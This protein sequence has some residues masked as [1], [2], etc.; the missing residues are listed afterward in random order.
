MNS[1]EVLRIVDAI[2][3]DKNIDKEIV[4]EGIEQAILSAARK[5]YGEERDILVTVDRESGEVSAKLDGED[6]PQEELDMLGRIA[7]QTAKQVMIQK[8]R[9]AE[10]DSLFDEFTA[11]RTELVTGTITRIDHGVAIVNLG[12]VEALLPRSEQIPGEAHRVNERVRAIVLEVRKAGS[13]VKVILSRTHPE[14]VRRLFEVEIPEVAE[15]VIEVRSLAREAGY[16]S[17]VAV[18]CYDNNIDAVGACV[19][20]RGSRIR[21]IV[22]ELAGERID[23]VRWNDSL[24][25]LI[26]N[27]LQPAE[28][29]DVILC[30]MLGRVIVLVKEDQLS[31]AIGKKGQNVRLA[32]KLVGWDIEVMTRE[33]LDEQLERS[34]GAFSTVPHITEELAEMLVSQGFFS[35]DDLSVIEPDQLQE[36]GGLTAEQC[37]EIVAHADVE[38]LREEEEAERKKA[39]ARAARIAAEAAA[40]EAAKQQ[41]PEESESTAE[42]GDATSEAQATSEEVSESSTVAEAE[43]GESDA[44]SDVAGEEPAVEARET[45]AVTADQDATEDKQEVAVSESATATAETAVEV[46]GDESAADGSAAEDTPPESVPEEDEIEATDGSALATEGAAESD[47]TPDEQAVKPAGAPDVTSAGGAN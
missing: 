35:F 5:N 47:E 21:S 10:R 43:H 7:A 39:E 23:I 6:I 36:L 40:A 9:E 12:K 32:S 11:V 3:R 30:P 29:E 37:D 33:E 13:R 31:L 27:A 41:T 46:A 28:V 1:T 24:Q 20:V 15:R 45:D 34:V 26:P 42:A 16:R 22:D 44:G 17:K 19:G 25:V 2:H 4:F 14:L 8:I 38:S 18:S